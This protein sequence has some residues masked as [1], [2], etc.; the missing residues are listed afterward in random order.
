MIGRETHSEYIWSDTQNI[1]TL[2][3]CFDKQHVRIAN[4]MENT[5]ILR[6]YYA[7]TVILSSG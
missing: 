7:A 2:F 5:A 1:C 4:Q 6:I 3:L